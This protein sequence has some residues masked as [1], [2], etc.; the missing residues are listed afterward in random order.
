MNNLTNL[1]AERQ[2]AF[3]E[4]FG[5]SPCFDREMEMS[6]KES[7]CTRKDQLIAF[8]RTTIRLIL[9]ALKAQNDKIREF[10]L[11]EIVAPDMNANRAY[12]K[13]FEKAIAAQVDAQFVG[14]T[15]DTANCPRTPPRQRS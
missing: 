3:E 14:T 2:D 11:R 7:V 1:I 6:K 12:D 4:E 13:G 5:D 10:G 15:N 8:N 9:E